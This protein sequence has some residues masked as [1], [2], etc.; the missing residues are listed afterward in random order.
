MIESRVADC[1]TVRYLKSG[2]Y[3]TKAKELLM[4][5]VDSVLTGCSDKWVV[6]SLDLKYFFLAII[7]GGLKTCLSSV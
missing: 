5:P 7:K 4:G 6:V 2:L 1:Q 3:L